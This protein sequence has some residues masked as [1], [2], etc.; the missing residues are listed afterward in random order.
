MSIPRRGQSFLILIILIAGLTYAILPEISFIPSEK[1]LMDDSGFSLNPD[2]TDNRKK[3]DSLFQTYVRQGEDL[4]IRKNPVQALTLFESAQ[5]IRPG[6]QKLKERIAGVKSMIAEQTRKNN[7]FMKAMTSGDVYFNS[8]DY[9]NAKA[10]YQVA[11]DLVPTDTIA[12]SKLRK[13]MD[14]LRSLKATNILYDVAVASAD[15]LFQA[16]EYEKARLEYENASKILPQEQYP[17]DKVNEIIK[18]QIDRQVNDELYAKAISAGDKFFLGKNYQSALLEFQKA[19]GIR[20]DEAYPKQKIAELT[21]LIAAQKATDEAY[22][23]AIAQADQSFQLL[24]YAEAIKGYQLALSIK[25][26]EVYPKNRIKEIEALIARKKG[27]QEEYE[28]Y[29]TLADSMYIGKNYLRARENYAMASAVK[30]S[31]A[32][33]KE[34]LAKADKMLTGREAEMARAM[35][36]QWTVTITTADKL[37]KDNAFEAARAEYLKASLLKPTEKYPV[38][39][40][41][42]IDKFLADKKAI[43]DQY[44]LIIANADKFFTQKS[45]DPAKSEYQKASGIKP[46]ESYPQTKIAEIDSIVKGIA[47]TRALDEEYK[48]LVASADKSMASQ[49]YEQARTDY[50]KAVGIKP[51]EVYPKTR[52]AEIDKILAGVTQQKA[53][54]ERYK[55]VIGEADSL[56]N[57]KAYDPSRIAYQNALK[58]K[59]SEVY[60]KNQVAE[61][62]KIL[63]QFAKEKSLGDQYLALVQRGE[64]QIQAKQFSTAKSSFE[65]ASGVK[66]EEKLPKERIA[67]IDSI[68]QSLAQ[69]KALDDKYNTVIVGADKLF[70]SKTYDM[71]RAEYVNAGNLKPSEQYP[72]DKIAEID[73]ALGAIAAKKALD[74]Q[75]VTTIAEA[76]KILAAKNYEQAKALYVNAGNLKPGEVY[77]KTRI[78]EIDKILAGVT[79]QKALEERYKRVIGEADSL[80]NLKAYD[81]SRIAYQNALKIKPSEVYPKNQVAEIDKILAQF[82]KEKSLGDQYLALVQRGETQ[83]QAKQFS[84]AK[85][86]FEQASGVK[87]EEKLPKERIAFIDSILQSLAQLKALDDKYN[88][89]IVGADKLFASKTYD[90]ARAEYVNA[91]NLKPSEQYPKD[92]IAEIDKALGAIAAKK[93]LDEQYVTTIAEADKILAAKNYEQAKTLYVNAGT[94]KPAE[95][96]PKTKITEIDKILAGIAR[97]KALDEEY[98]GTIAGADKLL[99][100]KSYELARVEYQKASGL[101]PAEQYPKTKIIEIDKALG[102]ISAKKAVDDQYASVLAAA[103]KLFG[104]KSWDQAKTGYTNA[105]KIKPS[106]QYPKDKITEITGILAALAKQKAIDDQYNGIIAKADQL[107]AAKTYDQARTEYVNAGNLKSGEQ[108][109]KD[110]IAEIDKALGE[111]AAKKALDGQYAAA[112]AEADKILAAKNYEQ[113]KTLYVNAGTLKPAEAYPKTKIT[114]IDKILAG[115]AR[116]KALDEE[117]AGTIAGA[118]KLLGEKS[119]ELARVEYQKASGLK[120][121]EQYPKTKIIEIDKALGDI[122]AK[123]AVDDQY[124][125]VLAAADK[126]FGEKSWDQAKT[127]YTNAGKIKPSEQYPKDKITEITGILAAL[128]KQKAIDDQYNGIIAKADQLLAAKTYDQAR[129]EYVNAGN[130]K[131]GEQYPKDKITEIDG[132]LSETKAKEEAYKASVTKADQLLASKKYDESSNEY[133]NALVIKPEAKY[134]SD[135]IAEI[136][137]LLSDLKGKRQTFDDLVSRGDVQ[138]NQKDWVKA[139]GLFQQALTIFPE[140]NYP[141]ERISQIGSKIDSIYRANRGKYDLAIAD[142]DRFYNSFEFDKAVDSYTIASDLLPMENYPRDMIS[143]IRKTIAENAIVDILKTPVTIGA[144][145]EKQFPFTPVNMASRKNNY[146]YIKIRNLSGKPFNVLMRYGQDKQPGGGV[147][148]RNLSVDGKVNDRLISVKD[149]DAWYRGDNNWISL[150]PQGGDVEVTFIQVS[151]AQKQ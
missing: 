118:D 6:D 77:P 94:L 111:I 68:L 130:L 25:P 128:A 8:K 61:I 131:S 4:L 44:R 74:E 80:Y 13:T 138:F 75:Y 145:E 39:K 24:R 54:E 9:V 142:G 71:A 27:E 139:R 95:A 49:G 63:A 48:T 149:Q 50:Q 90:M 104:E 36:Q 143:K 134:P 126:L 23:K 37:L 67:F 125:S 14:L 60:P 113:A 53:L 43:E 102:D 51:G 101:K 29:I 140:E 108:Y 31:E 146:V 110:K 141:K 5:K 83:I 15:K 107:L 147:V 40:I 117:Y 21:I 79:Q 10:S 87:P 69:L 65:Q 129:T 109:P 41:Q 92:K 73:K 137:K 99:G 85:S 116:E 30:P 76:D 33:P 72:K 133:Q 106:E 55:R 136:N 148:I 93:A 34:M 132:I 42:E 122:S 64:T 105:G 46:S 103:D 11:I 38:E 52:I 91:G 114:E 151:R 28:R 78:A 96:Y 58:I 18:I 89:V 19:Q 17:R 127:G 119:Y 22:N 98:A 97:E 112:I 62:D 84:T 135:K 26:A 1:E 20:P 57:L 2:S 32:Y 12:K 16:K 56:Y 82:A 70:A 3:Q 150:Y 86:S 120:P 35:D 88:T 123:K 124:A 66:P 7:D 100:E 121:A 59:P 47:R 81:P 115:I 144:G 45:Y